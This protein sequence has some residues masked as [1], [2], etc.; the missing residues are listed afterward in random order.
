MPVDSNQIALYLIFF[1]R[2]TQIDQS[3]D[4]E[5]TIL[6]ALISPVCIRGN[7]KGVLVHNEM[8]SKRNITS[9]DYR[10]INTLSYK[11][12]IHSSPPVHD[13]ENLYSSFFSTLSG[14]D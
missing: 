2:P 3:K 9:K 7:R 11:F 6:I 12:I 13:R 5:R 8:E 1:L 10:Q 14:V 4:L